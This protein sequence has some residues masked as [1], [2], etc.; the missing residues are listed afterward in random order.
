MRVS[1]FRNPRITDHVHLPAA[2]RSL[3]RLSSAQSAKASAPRPS[4]LDHVNP[5]PFCLPLPFLTS[6][7]LAFTLFVLGH[8][9]IA[10]YT[11]F[12]LAPR[13][14]FAQDIRSSQMSLLCFLCFSMLLF[15]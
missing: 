11:G 5:F 7:T 14:A 13:F 2:Y 3:S 9:Y 6:G 12:S 10:I 1:P 15:R 4:S 8:Q